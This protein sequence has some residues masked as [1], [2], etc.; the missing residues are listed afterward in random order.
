MAFR[1]SAVRSR[2]APHCLTAI[3][4]GR[5][6]SEGFT[7]P[8]RNPVLRCEPLGRPEHRIPVRRFLLEMA[9]RTSVRRSRRW[10]Y[11][12]GAVVVVLVILAGTKA[13]QIMSMIKAGKSF[14]PPPESVTSAK[15]EQV[16]WEA[17]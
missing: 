9:A 12:I 7:S 14:S 5:P 17:A 11:T 8:A 6:D 4:A 3:S 1:R 2:H 16:E 13:G 10:V 15:V